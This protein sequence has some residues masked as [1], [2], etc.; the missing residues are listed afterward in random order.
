MLLCASLALMR[1]LQQQWVGLLFALSMMLAGASVM[2]ADPSLQTA[3]ECTRH[4][5][6]MERI[7]DIPS[8]WLAAI[9]STESGRYHQRLR[10][11]VP[12]PWTINVA[13]KGY[14]FDT[15]QEAIN[16]VRRYQAQGIKSIDVGCMQVN[17]HY[18]GKNFASLEQAFEPIYNVSY[19]AKFL[20]Q[21]YNE[22]NSWAKATA[23]YHSMSSRGATYYKRVYDKWQ[24]VVDRLN[25]QMFSGSIPATVRD[26][27]PEAP[28]S[29]FAFKD[30]GNATST[31]NT[32]PIVPFKIVRP[33]QAAEQPQQRVRMNEITVTRG[34]SD[35][36]PYSAPAERKPR[37]SMSFQPTATGGDKPVMLPQRIPDT[38]G[39]N[40][41]RNQPVLQ[42]IPQPLPQRSQSMASAPVQLRPYQPQRPSPS[43]PAPSQF[44]PSIFD[45]VEKKVESERATTSPSR[46]KVRTYE[47]GVMVVRPRQDGTGV[48]SVENEG[49]NES[50]EAD[51]MG[52]AQED[53]RQFAP[54]RY[55]KQ[56]EKLRLSEGDG[57]FSPRKADT[58]GNS[59]RYVDDRAKPKVVSPKFVF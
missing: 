47:R 18:H 25:D 34:L 24:Q 39:M 52:R 21:K 19:A 4:L 50:N 22:F 28:T 42:P 54:S 31:R 15:K 14:W 12:W 32:A 51:I 17:L 37:A 55:E 27:M 41:M 36:N 7:Y 13:G 35:T 48:E 11:S 33:P 43:L 26:A 45:E 44:D 6:T 9:A 59:S 53:V 49:D 40:A 16:A 58:A 29:S 23:A 57:Q 20:K 5:P 1:R 3:Q 8:H 30:S 2:A 46:P 38:N 56:P 10:L